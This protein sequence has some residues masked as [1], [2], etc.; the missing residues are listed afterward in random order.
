VIIRSVEFAGAVAASGGALPGDLP[1]VAF[2]GR[3]NVGKSSLI[4]V[5]LG[6]TRKKVAHVSSNPGKTQTLNFY[7]VNDGFFLV[8]LPG[9]GY[10][11]APKAVRDSWRKTVEWYL[12]SGQGLRGVVHLVDGRHPPSNL[13]REMM[14]ILGGLCLPTLVI[15]T[16]MDRVSKGKHQATLMAAARELGLDPDQL[17]PFSSRTGEGK[18]DLLA[19]LEDLLELREKTACEP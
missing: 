12:A 18:D 19:A 13:D 16:K 17:L 15:L 7:R 5:I 9:F 14:E 4:N 11:K 8:D 6:R 10:A 1:Q 3:S 2:S